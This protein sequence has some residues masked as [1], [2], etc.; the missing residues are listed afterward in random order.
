MGLGNKEKEMLTSCQKVDPLV[1][2][3]IDPAKLR[4][5]RLSVKYK[6]ETV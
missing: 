4:M 3:Y 1:I 5:N 6:A 2:V